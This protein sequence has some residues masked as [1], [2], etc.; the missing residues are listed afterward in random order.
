[1]IAATLLNTIGRTLRN[2]T[3]Y[4]V[5]IRLMGEKATFLLGFSL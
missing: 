4:T 2:A 3:S 5:F 1:M